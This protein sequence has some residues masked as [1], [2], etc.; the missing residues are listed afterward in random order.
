MSKRTIN[1][2]LVSFVFKYLFLAAPSLDFD[3]GRLKNDY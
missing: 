3:I 2:I 1:T